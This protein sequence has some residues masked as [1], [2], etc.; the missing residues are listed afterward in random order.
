MAAGPYKK[1]R[2]SQSYDNGHF[3][4]TQSTAQTA[5]EH[6][7]VGAQAGEVARPD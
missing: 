6:D 2:L 3:D 7:A 5:R 4:G 1:R